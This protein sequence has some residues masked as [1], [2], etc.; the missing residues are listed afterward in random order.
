[1]TAKKSNGNGSRSKARKRGGAFRRFLRR[2]A[3]LVLLLVMGAVAAG[4]WAWRT[5]GQP[6]TGFTGERRVTVQPGASGPALLAPLPPP[7][8]LPAPPPPP[9]RLPPPRS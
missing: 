7:G 2:L 3:L 6:Y 4:W 8:G 1:M 5:I 9:A